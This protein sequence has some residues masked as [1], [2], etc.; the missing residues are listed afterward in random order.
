MTTKNK[1]IAFV[2]S[3]EV[4]RLVT[5]VSELSGQSK[6]SIVAEMMDEVSPVFMNQIETMQALMAAPDK[7]REY[8]EDYAERVTAEIAQEVMNFHAEETRLGKAV[9]KGIREGARDAA[10]P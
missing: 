10:K 8:V 4:L 5:K 2:P 1:R 6:A 7:A 3:D 9:N